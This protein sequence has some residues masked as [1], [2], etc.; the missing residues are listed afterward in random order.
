MTEAHVIVTTGENK[1]NM[2]RA[3]YDLFTYPWFSY[4]W[5][6]Q[7][8]TVNSMTVLMLGPSDVNIEIVLRTRKSM[9]AK[10]KIV[11]ELLDMAASDWDTANSAIDTAA[12][13]KELR[14]K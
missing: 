10:A 12:N 6:L 4:V 9:I 14:W 11:G 13:I 1:D 7:E 5:I 3:I 8:A 2:H